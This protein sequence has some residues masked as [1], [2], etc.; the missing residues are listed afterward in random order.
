MFYN[1]NRT[2]CP[3]KYIHLARVFFTLSAVSR[4]GGLWCQH[5]TTTRAKVRRVSEAGKQVFRRRILSCEE[6][7]IFRN[8]RRKFLGGRDVL[9]MM[10]VRKISLR[11]IMTKS[12]RIFTLPP[13]RALRP[14]LT[15]TNHLEKSQVIILPSFLQPPH[16]HHLHFIQVSKIPDAYPQSLGQEEQH[17][18]KEAGSLRTE[19][20]DH[21]T[22]CR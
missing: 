22:N 2:H 11:T 18:G 5:S 9:W 8:W 13:R 10:M 21:L 6:E 1:D 19:P 20:P 16:C 17:H 14:E 7:F 15:H 4:T 12:L 3:W